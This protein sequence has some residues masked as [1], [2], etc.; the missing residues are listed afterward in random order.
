M[1]TGK[2]YI[3][4]ELSSN[5]SVSF[6][7]FN[8]ILNIENS[9]TFFEASD[10]EIEKSGGITLDNIASYSHHADLISLS[11]LTMSAPPVDFSLHVI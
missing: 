9:I 4:G 11:G 5:S 2:N 10:I 3:G 7:T 1:I 6:K 8:P